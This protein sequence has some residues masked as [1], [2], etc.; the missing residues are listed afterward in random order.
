MALRIFWLCCSGQ[1]RRKR[2][3]AVKNL[4]SSQ[5]GFISSLMVLFYTLFPAIVSKV[6]LV[7]S[8]KTFGDSS[9][10]TDRLLLTEALTVQCLTNIHYV[11]V[12]T[13]GIP[14]VLLYIFLIPGII[15]SYLI[16]FRKKRELYPYQ[17]NYNPKWTLRLG[18]MFAGYREGYEWWES[19]VMVRK[20]MVVLLSIFLKSYGTTP[21]VVAAGVVLVTALSIQ[22]QYMP[23]QNGLHN[24]IES[25]G[26]HISL[27]QVLVVLMGNLIGQ[28]DVTESGYKLGPVSS[29]TIITIMFISTF[30]FFF[31]VFVSTVRSSQKNRGVVGKVSRRC[32]KCCP[33]FCRPSSTLAKTISSARI[34]EKADGIRLTQTKPS[35]GL[36]VR[37][38]TR[39]GSLRY[40][41]KVVQ[42]LARTKEGMKSYKETRNL[43]QEKVK[44]MESSAAARLQQRIKHR[45]RE[46][47]QRG[48]KSSRP[49]ARPEPRAAAAKSDVDPRVLDKTKNFSSKADS[50]GMPLSSLK[51]GKA[52]V[53]D[54]KERD[55]T[56]RP[57]I[58]LQHDTVSKASELELQRPSTPTQHP[59]AETALD[60]RMQLYRKIGTAKR[61]DLIMNKLKNKGEI[62]IAQFAILFKLVNGKKHCPVP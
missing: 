27:V 40:N 55:L 57:Q 60:L 33:R 35:I 3:T 30:V 44:S 47:L 46:N 28:I 6:A 11:M 9:R 59:L 48:E 42:H 8:C 12:L 23:Y 38:G 52:S 50:S 53:V 36:V 61:F 17:T 24:W 62:K 14:V 49:N 20:C 21:Q 5:D 56:S 34:R 37:Q 54:A 13:L 32:N 10:G 15:S 16:A 19:V 1:R 22:L 29:V 41:V 43:L 2:Y 7:F 4:V 58:E 31:Q 51:S 25:L 18:F 39:R 45:R 26:L